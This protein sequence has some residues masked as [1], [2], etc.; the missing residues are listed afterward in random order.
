MATPIL[1]PPEGRAVLVGETLLSA[2][3]VVWWTCLVWAH[4]NVL[5]AVP[6]AVTVILAVVLSLAVTWTLWLR[7]R[8]LGG[9]GLALI[10]V[11]GVAVLALS[12]LIFHDL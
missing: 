3:S 6:A 12:L 1:A 10:A 8:R 7:T 2:A 5:Y 9:A 11:R 4:R